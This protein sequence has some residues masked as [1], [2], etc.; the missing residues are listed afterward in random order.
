MI[1]LGE[2]WTA[3]HRNLRATCFAP[4][5][6]HWQSIALE[7]LVE[8]CGRDEL[9]YRVACR[10]QCSYCRRRGAHVET[11]HVGQVPRS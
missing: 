11:F 5:C 4:Q 2:L 7:D 3:G 8:R 10:L 6:R 9:L 1:K